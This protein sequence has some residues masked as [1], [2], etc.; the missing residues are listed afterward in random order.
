MFRLGKMQCNFYPIYIS[1]IF[2]RYYSLIHHLCF[3]NNNYVYLSD[4]SCCRGDLN[5]GEGERQGVRVGDVCGVGF[6]CRVC[7]QRIRVE[8]LSP[9]DERLHSGDHGDRRGDGI[10]LGSFLCLNR[11]VRY[12]WS[13]LADSFHVQLGLIKT[14][15]GRFQR[16]R[17]GLAF[18][19]VGNWLVLIAF[20]GNTYG[21]TLI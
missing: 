5:W 15:Q 10:S 19:N 18:C 21:P 12:G 20:T 2:N 13:F 9:S 1:T 11:G 16:R 7:S 17:A 14:A 8:R 6:Q 3:L 4:N